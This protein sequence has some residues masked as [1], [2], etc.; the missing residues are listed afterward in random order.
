[1]AIEFHQVTK[2]FENKLILDRFDWQLPETGI[3]C[4]FA[5]SGSG[6]TTLLRLLAGLERPDAGQIINVP[7]CVSIHFQENRLL[8]WYTARENLALVTDAPDEWLEKVLLAGEGARYPDELSG[9]MQRRVAFARALAYAADLL[10]L[11]EP[12]KEL[13]DAT[14]Q[15]MMALVR[16]QSQK[17][18]LIVWVTHNLEEA[19]ALSDRVDRFLG[20]PLQLQV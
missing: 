18:K 17:R 2:R 1:M 6:K 8:P 16:E 7:E 13:D 9:G 15:R 3:V 19:Q 12:F 11:D 14:V 20:P 5:P 10:L 4:L